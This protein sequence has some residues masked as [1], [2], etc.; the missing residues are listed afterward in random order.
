MSDFRIASR[1]AKTIFDLAVERKIEDEIGKDMNLIK[2][3]FIENRA[4]ILM[5]R[6]PVIRD[7]K[8]LGI[9]CRLFEGRIQEISLKFFS[10]L[11]RKSRLAVLPVLT[12]LYKELYNQHKG[13]VQAKI[14]MAM[15]PYPGVEEILAGYVQNITGKQAILEFE[16]NEEII[17]G[18][19]LTVEDKQLDRS[20]KGQ[21]KR[22]RAQLTTG[23]K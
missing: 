16:T 10:I 18:Y 8:K 2:Q 12:D 20:L 15:T 11:S 7:D 6:N 14:T 1:Y 3:T 4:L 23:K 5:L 19:I 13:Y 22:M 9:I 21:I 17:G